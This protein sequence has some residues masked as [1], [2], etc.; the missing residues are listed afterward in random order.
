MLQLT[1]TGNMLAWMAQSCVFASIAALLPLLF[2]V[3][4]PET[5]V[6]YGHTVIVVCVLLPLLQPWKHDPAAR[7]FAA[8]STIAALPP[9][10][11][12]DPKAASPPIFTVPLKTGPG[13]PLPA[14]RD[15][16]HVDVRE[17]RWF[18]WI[19]G[20][21]AA[22]KLIW[23]LGGLWRIR[24]YRIAAAPLYPVPETLK[25]AS[26]ITHADALFCLSENAPGP[27]MVGWLA[28][29]ILLPESFLGLSE[30]SQCGIGCH[31]LLHVR[32]GDWLVALLEEL[33]AALMWF[34]PGIWLLLSQTRL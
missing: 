3:R 34:N 20:G 11:T 5:R 16:V 30:E 25:A 8:G 6:V 12:S 28:P 27:V 15:S 24:T 1:F 32:R 22:L 2:R 33:I 23:M 9:A 4:H 18:F 29:V 21:G 31:E 17:G 10:A 26:A 14:D 7:Q 13:N 19:L